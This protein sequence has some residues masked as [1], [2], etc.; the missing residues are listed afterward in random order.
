MIGYNRLTANQGLFESK[1]LE[2]VSRTEEVAMV[3]YAADS[4]AARQSGRDD[5][6]DDES[7]LDEEVESVRQSQRGNFSDDGLNGS[8]QITVG[9]S[10][11]KMYTLLKG[12]T[13]EY[14]ELFA[15]FEIREIIASTTFPVLDDAEKFT[16]IVGEDT[17]GRIPAL[18]M[19]K[20]INIVRQKQ[21]LQPARRVFLSGRILEDDLPDFCGNGPDDKALLITEYICSGKS[22][23]RSIAALRRAGFESPNIAVLDRAALSNSDVDVD[24]FYMGDRQSYTGPAD[25]HLYRVDKAQKGVF[26]GYSDRHARVARLNVAQRKLLNHTRADIDHFAHELV[27]MW[28]IYNTENKQQNLLSKALSLAKSIH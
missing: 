25:S 23:R 27:A 15:G 14:S 21:G 11:E 22:A 16:T 26:K 28:E 18:I 1:P 24:T 17:S 13:W 4:L 7:W 19:G 6:I 3:K 9:P 8:R 5:L 10:C 12:D 20:A 2:L